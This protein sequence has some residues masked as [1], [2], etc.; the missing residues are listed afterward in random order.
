MRTF[1]DHTNIDSY[2]ERLQRRGVDAFWDGW[3]LNIF[4]PT[5][6][7]FNDKRG[8]YR[9]GQW[10]IVYRIKPNRYGAWRIP[11][12]FVNARAIKAARN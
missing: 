7:G 5:D 3:N 1:V 4:R 8:A 12:R 6:D 11:Q 2:V 10:G 9:N